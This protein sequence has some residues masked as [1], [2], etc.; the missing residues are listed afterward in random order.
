RSSVVSRNNSFLDPQFYYSTYDSTVLKK[1]EDIPLFP[2]NVARRDWRRKNDNILNFLEY[3]A[4]SSNKI[5]NILIAPGFHIESIDWHFDYS[6]DI[7][8]YCVDNFES[9]SYALSLLLQT[10]FFA[11]KENVKELIDEIEDQCEVK[12]YIYLTLCHETNNDSNYE[13]IDANWLANI[14]YTIHQL[15]NLGFKTII[16][17]SFMN[18]ILFSMLGCDYVAS[19]WFNTLR[20]FQKSRFDLTNSFGKRKKRY[21]SIPLLSNIMLDDMYGM[22][23]CD[24][25]TINDLLSATQIDSYIENEDLESVSFVDLEHQYWESLSILFDEFSQVEGVAN[26]IE[27]M[28]EKIKDANNLYRIAI[29][30][31]EG[32]DKVAATR[33]KN[34]SKHLSTWLSAIEIFKSIAAIV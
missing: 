25:L 4:E 6:I 29:D 21:T 27:V 32:E 30:Y 31:L 14:L 12:D 26:R 11:S 28:K 8:N 16:G 1:L 20:K 18:S 23:E 34:S 22:L 5:S 24:K 10:S 13:E 3:H 19:G 17:Y 2:I 15:Q 9:D 33:L 7:Y